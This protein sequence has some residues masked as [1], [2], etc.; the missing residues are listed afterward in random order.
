MDIWIYIWIYIYMDIYIWIYIYI[1][2]STCF[3]HERYGDVSSQKLWLAD[4]D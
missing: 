1:G 2:D 3:N 4:D